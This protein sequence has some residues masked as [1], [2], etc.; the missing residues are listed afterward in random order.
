MQKVTMA[1]K[2]RETVLIT[3]GEGDLGR[4]LSK[5]FTSQD[6]EVLHPGVQELDVR[7][8]RSVE[9]FFSSL[10]R[11]D[12][13]INNAGVIGDNLITRMSSQSWDH[14]LSVNLRGS[15]LCTREAM[16]RMLPQGNGQVIFIGSRSARYGTI[17]QCNYAASKAALIGLSQS[18]SKEYSGGGFRFNV[19]LPGF[20]ETKI[21]RGLSPESRQSALD[22]HTLGRFNTVDEA[23]RFVAFLASLSNVS[24]QVFQLDSRIDPWN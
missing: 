7:S 15:F 8:E 6:W 19:V 5:I 2:R 23:A 21:N 18:M 11:L 12:L 10:T 20:L 24:G 17:G 3:G 13:L 4:A 22:Q 9:L 16:K 14:V 1:G